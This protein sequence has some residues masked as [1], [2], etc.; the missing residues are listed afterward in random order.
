M[1]NQEGRK[2]VFLGCMYTMSGLAWDCLVGRAVPS[3]QVRPAQPG[4]QD[5][6]S[7][8]AAG[9]ISECGDGGESV[10]ARAVPGNNLSGL[11]SDGQDGGGEKVNPVQSGGAKAGEGGEDE[12]LCSGETGFVEV[13]C[14]HKESYRFYF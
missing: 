11:W 12:C 6:H 3:V 14:L 7:D 4:S 13:T 1:R 8:R 5:V 2:S 9:S 10:R